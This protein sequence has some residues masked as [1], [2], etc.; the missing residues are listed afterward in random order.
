MTSAAFRQKE[1]ILSWTASWHTQKERTCLSGKIS[2]KKV[3]TPVSDYQGPTGQRKIHKPWGKRGEGL[4][5][6]PLGFSSKSFLED[7][8]V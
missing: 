6:L 7:F 1:D 2:S 5:P 8:F 3:K 4:M